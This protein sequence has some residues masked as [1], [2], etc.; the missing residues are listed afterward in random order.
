MILYHIEYIMRGKLVQ[1][2]LQNRYLETIR[3]E[4][5]LEKQ[6]DQRH[7]RQRVRPEVEKFG[8]S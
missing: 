6:E 8:F 2:L 1:N 7:H 5:E 4:A 3:K